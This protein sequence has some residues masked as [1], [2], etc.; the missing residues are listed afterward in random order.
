MPDDPR[1]Q[2]IEARIDRQVSGAIALHASPGNMLTIAPQNMAELFEFAK[3]MAVSGQCIRPVFRGNPGACLA[4]ALQAFRTGAD[5]FAVANKAYLVN[6]QIAYES[7]YIHAV[8]NSSGMLKKR[9]RATYSGDGPTRKCTITGEIVGEDEPLPYESPTVAAIPVKNSPLWKNDPD[10][11]LFY[12]ASRAWARRYLPEVTLG[13]YTGD[14]MDHRVIDVTPPPKPRREDFQDKPEPTAPEA[15]AEPEAPDYS[16]DDVAE[17]APTWTVIFPEGELRE[18]DS[19]AGAEESL[20]ALLNALPSVAALEA[21]WEDNRA[22]IADSPNLKRFDQ[23]VHI[24]RE[25]LTPA[26]EPAQQP[27]AAPAPNPPPAQT[28]RP[29]PAAAARNPTP[30]PEG[31]TIAREGPDVPRQVTPAGAAP[32]KSTKI[33]VPVRKDGTK[34]YRVWAQVAFLSAAR[35]ATPD[36]LPFLIGDHEEEIAAY[37]NAYPI[38]AERFQ[39]QLDALFGA[40]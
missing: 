39:K 5:P 11:Q 15:A 24:L 22:L 13:M 7:Q 20:S 40:E 6:D 31:P 14:E 34:D 35:R 1:T 16:S 30:S 8:I 32:P 19:L 23:L 26:P 12:Y 29:A 10:Q 17:D 3:M 28:R 25:R 4:I 2:Q 18:F 9:L 21:V 33:P 37:K 27:E 36:E 38:E